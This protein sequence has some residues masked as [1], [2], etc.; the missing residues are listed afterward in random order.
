MI[1]SPSFVMELFGASY[2]GTVII[3]V[4]FILRLLF[5]KQVPARII[6]AGWVLAAMVWLIPWTLP[7]AWSPMPQI[8]AASTTNTL[9][10]QEADR[11]TA[12]AF[13]PT[14]VAATTV[15]PQA[16]AAN[17]GNSPKL[18]SHRFSPSQLFTAV[19]LSVAATLLAVRIVNA[20]VINRRVQ[21]KSAPT[22]PRLVQA[23][24]SLAD[25]LGISNPPTIV[26]SS[27]VSSPALFG[28]WRPRILFPPHLAQQLSDSELRWV[29]LHELGHHQRKDLLGLSILHLAATIHW[30]NPMAWIALRYG[31][32]DAE[33]ACD[34]LVL[35][36][37]SKEA[38]EVY[39]AVLLKVLGAQSANPSVSTALG[40]VEDKR[41]LMNRLILIMDFKRIGLLRLTSSFAVLSA[42]A[43]AGFTQERTVP[44]SG[45]AA[46][47]AAT[48][49]AAPAS[50]MN[51]NAA[52]LEAR[53]AE[54]IA[55]EE[56]VKLELRAVGEVGGVPVAIV[57]MEGSPI[58]VTPSIGIQSLFVD[59]FE[60]TA[61]EITVKTRSGT[62]RVLKLE[63]PSP[64]D[65]P[66]VNPTLL[67]TPEAIAKRNE[68]NRHERI[69]AALV[70]AWNKI[71]RAGKEA[72]L[73]NYLRSGEVVQVLEVS[74]GYS[75][76]SGFLFSE[77]LSA[78]RREQKE[79]FLASLTP[80]QKAK[81]GSG[82]AAAI[83]FTDS[84]VKIHEQQKRGQEAAARRDEV[85]ASLTPE[86]KKLYDEWMGPTSK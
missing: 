32:M 63:N 31:R 22:P 14:P 44:N 78:I 71:N 28:I 8:A 80:E 12:A 55:W 82:A 52:S 40:I 19:W 3:L 33:I 16:K 85:I 65:F 66:K 84:A 5:R 7:V 70:L 4:L 76:A 35:R 24:Q 42:L 45:T 79:K 59:A 56:N 77:R 21:R 6:S 61:T 9:A 73:L 23:L 30:F 17:V 51:R 81:F 48:A 41:Q 86:Q 68:S 1:S 26:V 49:N 37:R 75:T 72:I 64:V 57:D 58:V 43:V 54:A 27:A 83:R 20:V 38:P 11:K 2:R 15:L 34:D 13:L 60:A 36:H 46:N 67:L 53:R 29:L 69:P 10:D 25:E 47:P 74:G 50:M 18:N 62:K 39:G